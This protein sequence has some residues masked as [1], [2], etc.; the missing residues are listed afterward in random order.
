[1]AVIQIPGRV[2]GQNYSFNIAGD[3]P[4]PTEQGRIAQALQIEE[5][6]HYQ[7]DYIKQQQRLHNNKQQ[8]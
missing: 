1:M 4:T 3:I 2:S 8:Q 6:Y 7:V 5:E